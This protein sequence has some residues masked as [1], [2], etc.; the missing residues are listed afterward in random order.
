MTG[1]ESKLEHGR[2]STEP[3]FSRGTL[4]DFRTLVKYTKTNYADFIRFYTYNNQQTLISQSVHDNYIDAI[5]DNH[6][7]FNTRK[8]QFWVSSS[9]KEV[10]EQVKSHTKAGMNIFSL[11]ADQNTGKFYV[12]MIDDFG[13]AQS[14]IQN[15][16]PEDLFLLGLSVTS[17]TC[18]NKKYFFVMTAGVSQFENHEQVIFTK[19][20]RSDLDIEIKKQRSEGKV[21]TSFCI[22]HELREYLVVMTE[23]EGCEQASGWFQKRTAD[24]YRERVKWLEIYLRRR[25]VDTIVCGDSSDNQTFYV[26][27]SDE[28]RNGV[29]L[30][31]TTLFS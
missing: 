1:S 8:K 27:T 11:A 7:K 17:V 3:L 14:I 31:N 25:L 20:N 26:M 2:P 28:D 4:F 9:F 22:N 13:K 29:K 23:M 21:I 10:K 6:K 24:G 19:S 16:D 18:F 12:F 30:I 5:F 15:E